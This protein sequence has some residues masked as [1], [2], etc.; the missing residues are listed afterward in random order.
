M[1]AILERIENRGGQESNLENR[2]Q[3]A[4][5]M[6]EEAGEYDYIVV[7]DDLDKAVAQ[8]AGIILAERCK[9]QRERVI[10][11]LERQVEE[12]KKRT[13]QPLT[14]SIQYIDD[15]FLQCAECF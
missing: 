3:S 1:K 6:I 10:R 12:W 15:R 2:L 11:D 9:R 8:L 4:V 5:R 14:Q 13:D 7:N